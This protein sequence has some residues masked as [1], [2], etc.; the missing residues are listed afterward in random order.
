MVYQIGFHIFTQGGVSP[1]CTSE[2]K[3][4]S[5]EMIR[6]QFAEFITH[7]NKYNKLYNKNT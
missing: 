7:V 4:K 2:P 1:S 6:T 3:T 5:G